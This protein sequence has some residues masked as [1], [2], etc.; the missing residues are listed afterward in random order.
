LLERQFP[1]ERAGDSLTLRTANDFASHL[2]VHINYLN[3]TVKEM[4]GKSTSV[5]IAERIIAEAKALLLHTDCTV[6]E[7]AD[8]LG[9][10]YPTYFNNYFKRLTGT[11]PT[12]FRKV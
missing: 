4:T 6:A 7:I 9:F 3:R 8:V 2:S 1:L 5:H 11:T 12:S 10:E